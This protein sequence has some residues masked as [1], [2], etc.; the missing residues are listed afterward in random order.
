MELTRR[1]FLLG[2]TALLTVAA[3]PIPKL[4]YPY[5]YGMDLAVGGSDTAVFLTTPYDA[6][7]L[8]Q[9]IIKIEWL[10]KEPKWS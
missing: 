1:S 2:T 9:R 4:P 5:A 6:L 8:A 10:A 3:L 7:K